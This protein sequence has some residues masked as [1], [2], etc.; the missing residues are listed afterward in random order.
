MDTKQ[1]F[2]QIYADLPLSLRQEIIVV[3][4]DEPLTWNSARVEIE[5]DTGKGKQALKQLEEMGIIK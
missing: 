4:G 5:N 2:F 1:R 3:I